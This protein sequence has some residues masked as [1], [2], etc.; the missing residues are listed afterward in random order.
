MIRSAQWSVSAL[1]F[2][3]VC[4]GCGGSRPVGTARE[5][6]A[7]IAGCYTVRVE[8]S[9]GAQVHL[10]LLREVG[11]MLRLYEDSLSP[12]K[13]TL[14]RVGLRRGVPSDSAIEAAYWLR[15]WSV[16]EDSDSVW[17]SIGHGY[18]GLELALV[19][20]G[21]TL[22]G[23]ASSFGDTQPRAIPI[24]RVLA[25]RA[26]CAASSERPQHTLTPG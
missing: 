10:W 13:P 14:H 26:D 7:R 5:R 11:G 16:D 8:T 3:L 25:V 20:R 15:L 6:V 12:Q 21:D 24:G 17:V 1:S 19:P 9:T 22:A 2:V 23:E 18:G 4:M